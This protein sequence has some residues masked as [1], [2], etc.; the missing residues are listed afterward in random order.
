MSHQPW[1]EGYTRYKPCGGGYTCHKLLHHLLGSHRALYARS[2]HK[3]FSKD[4]LKKKKFSSSDTNF[5][6]VFDDF[7]NT[8]ENRSLQQSW[9]LLV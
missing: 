1:A 3:Q 4:L 8:G 6:S 7:R 9:V 2:K 5:I